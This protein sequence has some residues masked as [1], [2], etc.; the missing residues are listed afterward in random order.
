MITRLWHGWTTP[1]NADTYEQL[2]TAEIIPAIVNRKM[3]G[4][5]SIEVLRRTHADEVEFITLMQFDKL[6][7]I[8]AFVG[9]D[10]EVAHIPDTAR[11]IL[12]RF[13]LR[14]QH[15]HSRNVQQAIA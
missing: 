15:Y 2:L 7:S 10:Y 14:A 5:L 13:D 9:E 1:Q 3:P 6:Q 12:S 4:F 8:V 11:K